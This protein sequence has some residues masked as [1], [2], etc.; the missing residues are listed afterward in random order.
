MQVLI[1]HHPLQG[2]PLPQPCHRPPP[3]PLCKILFLKSRI[4]VSGIKMPRTDPAYRII[5]LKVA[6]SSCRS[7]S[8]RTKILPL[9][10]FLPLKA[11]P[12]IEVRLY[13]DP[14]IEARHGKHINKP[15]A[16]VHWCWKI[17]LDRKRTL[18]SPWSAWRLA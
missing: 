13:L 17:V 7:E 16:L 8:K 18:F 2:K 1:L 6:H 14:S 10:G 15:G 12:L 5:P 4:S 11:V 3:L 9:K